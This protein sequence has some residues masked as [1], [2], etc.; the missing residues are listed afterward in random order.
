MIHDLSELKAPSIDDLRAEEHLKPE[1]PKAADQLTVEELEEVREV[2]AP[3]HIS[4]LDAL[5]VAAE[6]GSDR[7]EPYGIATAGEPCPGFQ[8]TPNAS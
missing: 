1:K 5:I 8:R 6:G 4:L 2:A 7:T 3:G